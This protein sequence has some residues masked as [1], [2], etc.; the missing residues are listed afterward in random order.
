[1]KKLF[2]V[3]F[4]LA[5]LALLVTPSL[6]ITN[7]QPD[8]AGHPNV[9]TILLVF[10]PDRYQICSGTLIS[11][12][13]FLTA[14][15]CSSYL[16]ELIDRAA[17]TLA[18]VQVSFDTDNAYNEGLIPVLGLESHP[19]Y[20][21]IPGIGVGVNDLGVLYLD[22]TDTAGISP[23]TLPPTGFLD[24]LQADGLLRTGSDGARFVAVGYGT[25]LSWPPPVI[26]DGGG[27]RRVSQ[28]EFRNLRR[29][30]LQM[31]QNQAPGN[32]N[33]GTC[34]GDS[35][36]PNFWVQPDGSE[37]LVSVTSWGDIPCVA[38]NTTQRTD[39]PSA[40]MFLQ[41]VLAAHP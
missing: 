22:P 16:E 20:Q 36:G 8:G 5:L 38:T 9:G 23:A 15:H 1:M 32:N 37:V 19:D 4:A 31:S 25:V 39:S 3:L 30:W 6:A 34:Y 17:I 11:P 26:T 41:D 13:V 18:N 24:D 33:G 7:G 35:G 29:Q 27:V 10:G 28:S 2:S 12:Q 21:P 14:A 40:V